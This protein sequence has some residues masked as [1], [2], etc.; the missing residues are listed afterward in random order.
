MKRIKKTDTVM[1]ISGRE[2]GKSGAVIEISTKKN[3]VKVKQIGLVSKHQKPR[4]MGQSGG[5]K[6]IESW[7]DLSKVMPICLSCKK[8]TRGH[9]NMLQSGIR[10]RTCG[11]CKEI[12]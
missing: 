9:T 6:K 8:V 1:V 3:A 12:F 10:V 4:K 11:K 7:I 2:Q 5:I